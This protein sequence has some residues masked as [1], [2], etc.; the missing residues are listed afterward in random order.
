MMCGVVIGDVVSSPG[1]TE[2]QSCALAC[3]INDKYSALNNGW[4]C[5]GTST[6]PFQTAPTMKAYTLC[7]SEMVGEKQNINNFTLWCCR[8]E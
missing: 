6:H 5:T 1:Q 7:G 4:S 3:H 2:R 8:Q